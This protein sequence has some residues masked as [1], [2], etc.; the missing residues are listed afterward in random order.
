M[1]SRPTRKAALRPPFARS[2]YRKN[3]QHPGLNNRDRHRRAHDEQT[4]HEAADEHAQH[5]R[6]A[7]IIWPAREVS[8]SW[9]GHPAASSIP[10]WSGCTRPTMPRTAART[11]TAQ[12]ARDQRHDALPRRRGSG[13]ARGDEQQ[14]QQPARHLARRAARSG[15]SSCTTTALNSSGATEHAG[16]Q[17]GGHAGG[18]GRDEEQHRQDARCSTGGSPGTRPA[19]SRCRRRRTGP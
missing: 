4:Q 16:Q 15:T 9:L 7:L 11:T 2:G 3:L 5:P 13:F 6:S 10:G 1:P 19:G 12:L 17:H 8:I 18:H 14:R